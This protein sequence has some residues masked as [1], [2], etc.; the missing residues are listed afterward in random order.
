MI[1]GKLDET[2]YKILRILQENARIDVNKLCRLVNRTPSPV[3]DRIARLQELGYI[4]RYFAVVDRAL[5]GKPVLVIAMVTLE[6]QTKVLLEEFETLVIGFSQVQFVTHVSGKW[7]FILHVVAE[8]P[9]H[10]YDFLMGTL[11]DL[12]NVAHV[13]SSFVLK[14]SKTFSP[15]ELEG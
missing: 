2:D 14:E 13:E 15:L 12:P 4:R 9:Q 7:D 6:K 1:A 10:Y 8:S 3:A 11:C 5:V